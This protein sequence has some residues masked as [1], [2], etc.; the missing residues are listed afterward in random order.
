MTADSKAKND[1]VISGTPTM[2]VLVVG[3]ASV[4]KSNIISRYIASK[5]EHSY[6]RTSRCQIGVKFVAVPEAICLQLWD[7]PESTADRLM[8]AYVKNADGVIVVTD[9]TE[10][11]TFRAILQWRKRLQAA[12]GKEK[13]STFPMLLLGNKS[14]SDACV[15]DETEIDLSV[16]SFGLTGGYLVSAANNLA[17]D[18]AMDGFAHTIATSSEFQSKSSDIEE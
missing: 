7:I 1:K 16:K 5:F 8:R 13:G 17:L 6:S 11:I 9:T 10:P 2:K 3:R 15:M 4:G 14:E 18:K 12:L